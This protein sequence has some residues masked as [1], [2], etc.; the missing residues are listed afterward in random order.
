MKNKELKKY[1]VIG[2]DEIKIITVRN[3]WSHSS[4]Y[5]TTGYTNSCDIQEMFFRTITA[6]MR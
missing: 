5:N 6:F 2:T 3:S 4:D 1:E